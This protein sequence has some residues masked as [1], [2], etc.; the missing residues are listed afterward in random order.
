LPD[1][2]DNDHFGSVVT[3]CNNKSAPHQ[4]FYVAATSFPTGSGDRS[5]GAIHIFTGSVYQS[6]SFGETEGGETTGSLFGPPSMSFG[7]TMEINKTWIA[8][9]GLTSSAEFGSAGQL[10]STSSVLS[11]GST[12]SLDSSKF[13]NGVENQVLLAFGTDT[14]EYDGIAAPYNTTGS[15]MLVTL[16]GSGNIAG[17]STKEGNLTILPVRQL[18]GMA[19]G[20]AGYVYAQTAVRSTQAGSVKV[21]SASSHPYN[22]G[23]DVL[24]F[25]NPGSARNHYL[26]SNSSGG[27][28]IFMHT[29]SAFL[30]E[31]MYSG[32]FDADGDASAGTVISSPKMSASLEIGAFFDYKQDGKLYGLPIDSPHDP[33]YCAYT[34]P[35]YYG[36]SIAR[37]SFTPATSG[38]YGLQ[39]I[40][41]NSNVEILSNVDKDK[42]AVFSTYDIKNSL[43][44]NQ[45]SAAMGIKSSI[46]LFGK[47]F[48][49]TVEF[50]LKDGG[51]SAEASSASNASTTDNRRWVISTKFE[52]PILDFQKADSIHSSSYSSHTGSAMVSHNFGSKHS[53]LPP[54]GMWMS[55]G[56]IPSSDRGI[57]MELKESY[58]PGVYEGKT[59]TTG[60][61]LKSL[62]FTANSKQLGKV[63][64]TKEIS[65]AICLIPYVKTPTSERKT[66]Y[67]Q[68]AKEH[69]S[70][71]RPLVLSPRFTYEN[72]INYSPDL[73]I[74]NISDAIGHVQKRLR[75]AIDHNLIEIPIDEFLTQKKTYEE[76]S[77][78][79]AVKKENSKTGEEIRETSITRMLRGLE[80]YIL[81]PH[82]DPTRRWS[83]GRSRANMDQNPFAMYFIEVKHE[84]DKED[85]SNIWQNVS[86]GVA[87]DFDKEEI[88]ITH[89]IDE[90]NFFTSSEIFKDY[91]NDDLSFMVFKVKKRAKTNYFDT[92][93]DSTDDSRF[94]FDLKGDNTEVI[95]EYSY[96]WPYDYFSLIENA[97]ITMEVEMEKPEPPIPPPPPPPPPKKKKVR[98][99][100]VEKT[101]KEIVKPKKKVVKPKLAIKKIEKDK[102][103]KKQPQKVGN[104]YRATPVP[105][106]SPPRKPKKFTR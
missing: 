29:G 46:N 58:Q 73:N 51:S 74:S 66:F 10:S 75:F 36:S 14:S 3:L 41:T 7:K 80:E 93:K 87:V 103:Q 2:A 27:A 105:K 52:S 37:L 89:D 71:D 11:L 17:D 101:L 24:V 92:T 22:K 69:R 99:K 21:V 94:R 68:W 91:L 79:I 97:K 78:K 84:L 83:R 56:T 4:K 81:P 28:Y 85:L 54:R 98:R 47:T 26:P 5:N 77:G 60:S 35:S 16:H 30:G 23:D 43:T 61:L 20:S 31:A 57:F 45:K 1:G 55:Y 39:E 86:P 65:E 44:A 88:D 76:S 48:D 9:A 90:H 50:N 64:E 25:S 95:P 100:H 82:L 67:H 34:P 102:K 18:P 96:N 32:S 106:K 33:A 63:R 59:S 70:T 49:P 13:S 104:P 62:G 15:L 42:C 12:L 53:F 6:M 40:F 38:R 8:D 19:T 72:I